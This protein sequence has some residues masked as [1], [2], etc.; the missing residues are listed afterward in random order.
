M[1]KPQMSLA[2]IM[3]HLMAT[4]PLSRNPFA[5]PALSSFAD[6]LARIAADPMLPVRTRQN[7][8]W[9]LRAVARAAG[10]DPALAQAHPEFLRAL[11]KRAAPASIGLTPAAWNNA[12]SLTGKVL[13]WAGL[14]SM[15]AHYQAPFAP[16]WQV[17][18]D[19]LPPGKNALRMQLRRLFHFCSAQGV[20][21]DEVDDALLARF[22]QDLVAESI[23]EEPHE[24]YRGASKS[25]NNAA[26][27]ITGWPQQ[28]LS[29]PSKQQLFTLPWNTF[30]QSLEDDVDA[31]CRRAAGLNLDDDHFNRAQRPATIKTRRGQARVLATAIVRSG[32]GSEVL[33]GLKAVLAP[34]MAAQGLQYLLDRNNGTSN[35]MI[36]NIA[37]FLPTLARRLDMSE[38][39]VAKLSKM[40]KKLKVTQYGM[41]ARN[42]E[43]L[44]AFDDRAAVEGL[45]TLPQRILREVRASGRRGYREAKLIQTALAIE[46]LLNAPVRIQNLAS[47]EI[48]RHLV[49]GGGPR[50][51]AVQLHFP[52]IEVK[53]ASNLDFPLLPE[54]LELLDIYMAEWRPL[55]TACRSPFLFPGEQPDRHK[56]KGAL[57]SQIKERVYAHTRLEMPAHRFRHAV[58]KIYLDLHPGQYEVVRLLLGHKDI[59]TTISFYAGAESASAARHYQRTILGIRNGSLDVEPS[60]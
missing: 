22:H 42:R 48:K 20:A 7:W 19:K 36:S 29:V 27:R 30:P 47:I 6:L 8:S 56:G 52:A 12:R 3:S 23:V 51:R 55:L 32:T 2:V 41:T 50:G 25:W 9:A 10:I 21:P 4:S 5:D 39:V 49:D 13:Q 38:E 53:N 17:L 40:A 26:D 14:A 57:S 45:V 33:V 59:K 54:A 34:E 28:R 16:A 46:L 43:A 35:V 15:P 24:T 37:C 60:A 18:W 58:G 31:Y 44:R 11:F 1:N